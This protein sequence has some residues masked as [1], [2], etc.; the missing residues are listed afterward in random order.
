MKIT[1]I[2]GYS[3]YGYNDVQKGPKFRSCVRVY[4]VENKKKFARPYILTATC[5][6]RDCLD[7]K[8]LPEFFIK[9]FKDKSKVNMFCFGVSDGSEAYSYAMMIFDRFPEVLQSKFLPIWASD[10]DSKVINAAKTLKINITDDDI[11]Q[12]ISRNIHKLSIND[13]FSYNSE[14]MEIENDQLLNN[15]DLAFSTYDIKKPLSE[16]VQ[17]ECSDMTEKLSTIDDDGNT[18]I[19]CR[20]AL[21]YMNSD[22]ISNFIQKLSDT[23]KSNSVFII[24]ANDRI[25]NIDK[26]LKDSGFTEVMENVFRRN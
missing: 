25:V 4:D 9:N 6:F 18:I 2:G 1:P 10:I 20:N 11:M 17:F 19:S 22:Y 3:K 26:M 7:W 5:F 16:S 23:L 15:N 8:N 14:T 21:F 12:K 24:G 13:C